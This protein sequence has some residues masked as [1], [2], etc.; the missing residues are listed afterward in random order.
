LGNRSR[1]RFNPFWSWYEIIPVSGA[2]LHGP[3]PGEIGSVTVFTAGI[4]AGTKA[5]EADKALIEFLSGLVAVPILKVKGSERSNF[6]P[7][8]LADFLDW[9]HG[10][11][12]Q[13][14]AMKV[15]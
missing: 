10:S 8:D 2:E 15:Y 12:S 4:S 9:N 5:S 7:P 13:C 3:L 1:L 14:R 11:P 6:S